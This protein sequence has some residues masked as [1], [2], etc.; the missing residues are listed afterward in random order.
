MIPDEDLLEASKEGNLT[1]AAFILQH[2]NNTDIYTIN[3]ALR[4]VA[5]LWSG[6]SHGLL[7]GHREI[8]ALL[9]KHPK[10]DV[11]E[12]GSDRPA[13]HLASI[14]GHTEVV[15]ILAPLTD[16]PNSPNRKQR[17]HF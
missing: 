10:I 12:G 14:Y 7:L 11:N 5:G 16:Y 17:R 9:L 3:T 1:S 2:C 4:R 6:Y 13:L 15:K 8:V